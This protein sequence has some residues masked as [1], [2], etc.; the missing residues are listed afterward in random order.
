[1]KT[2]IIAAMTRDRVIGREGGVPWHEPEDLRH[3]KRTT[4]GHAV[5]MG[6]KTF[7]SISGPLP[8][9]RNIVVTRNPDYK[10]PEPKPP[11]P[12]PRS[13]IV[14]RE[15][16]IVNRQSSIDIVHSLDEALGL[17]R[18]RNEEKAFIVGGAQIYELALPIADEMIITRIDRDDVTGDTYF[19]VWYPDDWEALPS[20]GSASLTVARYRRKKH[21]TQS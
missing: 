13:P 6:R 21:R 14:N 1:M 9:R 20:S 7:E 17:C 19:P 12:D 11:T 2:I 5:I 3:F 18:D 4:T 16:S 10:P 8:N 15:S